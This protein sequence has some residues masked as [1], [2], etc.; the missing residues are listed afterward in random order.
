MQNQFFEMRL[1]PDDITVLSVEDDLADRKLIAE[2]LEKDVTAARVRVR[3]AGSGD[4]ALAT[5]RGARAAPDVLLLD[6][7]LPGRTGLEILAELRKD[8]TIP[9]VPIFVLSTSQ[10][11]E[12]VER[13]LSLGATRFFT[14]PFDMSELA[15]I[16]REIVDTVIS[17]LRK[18][19]EGGSAVSRHG[20]MANCHPSSAHGQ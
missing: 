2:L 15:A 12:D 8:E 20:G 11:E 1:A 18:P 7:N 17:T 5:L 14:K 3:F 10:A 6:L 16:L 4:E 19:S 9:R 13:C